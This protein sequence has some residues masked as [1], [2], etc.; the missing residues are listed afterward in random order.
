MMKHAENPARWFQELAREHGP[1]VGLRMPGGLLVAVNDHASIHEALVDHGVHF[2]DR[3]D[4][5]VLQLVGR[6]GK[7]LINLLNYIRLVVFY[8]RI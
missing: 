6:R 1:V 8:T 5:L 7:Y 4:D 2:N 3:S